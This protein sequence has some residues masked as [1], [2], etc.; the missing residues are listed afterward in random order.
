M[1]K[2]DKKAENEAAEAERFGQNVS[3]FKGMDA[4]A[5]Q[6]KASAE[7]DKAAESKA[8]GQVKDTAQPVQPM[9]QP[10][11]YGYPY[12]Q[13]P[14]GQ[15]QAEATEKKEY[16]DVRFLRKIGR[17][18]MRLL[19]KAFGF[20][21]SLSSGLVRKAYKRYVDPRLSRAWFN[22]TEA[23]HN[24]R[25]QKG[26][27]LRVIDNKTGD[28]I[29]QKVFNRNHL[30]KDQRPF[31][32]Q[33]LTEEYMRE[34]I[35]MDVS[36][37]LYQFENL[38]KVPAQID[39]AWEKKKPLEVRDIREALW[40][41]EHPEA[42]K[43]RDM[44]YQNFRL[45]Q[46]LRLKL[47]EYERMIKDGF[48]SSLV[49]KIQSDINLYSSEG[50][51]DFKAIIE[52]LDAQGTK[53]VDGLEEST[54]SRLLEMIQD[55]CLSRDIDTL[56]GQK[57]TALSAVERFYLRLNHNY[58]EKADEMIRLHDVNRRWIK[59]K[60][61]FWRM[62]D[63][64]KASIARE[65]KQVEHHDLLEEMA[66]K[67][68]WGVED[69]SR[70][71]P[72]LLSQFKDGKLPACRYLAAQYDLLLPQNSNEAYQEAERRFWKAYAQPEIMSIDCERLANLQKLKTN[73]E[74]LDASGLVKEPYA[75]LIANVLCNMEHV[76]AASKGL[77]ILKKMGMDMKDTHIREALNAER[78]R[79]GVFTADLS[80]PE[81]GKKPASEDRGLD[82]TAETEGEGKEK[83]KNP[84]TDT[85]LKYKDTLP[86]FDY[87]ILFQTDYGKQFYK[88]NL[89]TVEELREFAAIVW[90]EA[91]ALAKQEKPAGLIIKYGAV[92][93]LKEMSDVKDSLPQ[94]M[95]AF[96]PILPLVA[97]AIGLESK[98]ALVEKLLGTVN[99]R[100]E[101][102]VFNDVTPAKKESPEGE[103]EVPLVEAEVVPMDIFRDVRDRYISTE[104]IS[105]ISQVKQSVSSLDHRTIAGRDCL[106]RI[107]GKEE[108]G[109]I[110]VDEQ[111]Q[112][113][114]EMGDLLLIME[115]IDDSRL[116]KD[117]M[118][119][120]VMTSSL[121]QYILPKVLPEG[122]R[123]MEDFYSFPEE[124]RN[125]LM[126][127]YLRQLR[128]GEKAKIEVS[129][130]RPG[131][132]R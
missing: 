113:E 38:K 63:Y 14:A 112:L 51:Q 117:I 81:R 50:I 75:R 96:Q 86:E 43:E 1:A 91:M 23:Y 118:A 130:P 10:Y 59:A 56:L 61:D 129:A 123:S 62:S 92:R 132:H 48:T 16:R 45:H 4:D 98:E 26:A 90:A 5:N 125:A 108:I 85:W 119:D 101:L 58:Y 60:N 24:R 29:D 100:D 64:E 40:R 21:W 25:G 39:D 88:E 13:Q 79:R 89:Q 9:Q 103:E 54:V 111:T 30:D 34:G 131:L 68:C 15:G 2:K 109:S 83:K 47:S 36:F 41:K 84:L 94:L 77:E 102:I 22:I 116:Q 127:D 70:L 46:D 19:G 8:D 87:E 6:S 128:S 17:G 31:D 28:V 110:S 7:K 74:L 72:M 32:W 57:V 71:S 49:R 115:G 120:V 107:I 69:I 97:E 42:D 126:C 95:E 33:R 67:L 82:D 78:E 124:K 73:G 121:Y 106:E 44:D 105:Q 55:S 104:R 11:P 53:W 93:S 35:A 12:P 65:A 18:A 76:G 66:Y 99:D 20:L 3:P 52:L 122:K 37:K 114:K 80:E 27:V